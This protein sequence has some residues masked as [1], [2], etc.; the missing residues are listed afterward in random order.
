[1]QGSWQWQA[2]QR[3]E[4]FKRYRDDPA[5]NAFRLMFV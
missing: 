2:R 1:M 5:K 4:A 3:N